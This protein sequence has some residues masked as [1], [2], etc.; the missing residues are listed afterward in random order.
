MY[1]YTLRNF[2]SFGPWPKS[3]LPRDLYCYLNQIEYCPHDISCIIIVIE[4]TDTQIMPLRR[5]NHTHETITLRNR[6][7]PK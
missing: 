7:E 2:M 1:M 4:H 5:H 6:Y 3:L